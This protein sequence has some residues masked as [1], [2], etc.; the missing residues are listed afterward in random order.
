MA[1]TVA[2]IVLAYSQARRRIESFKNLLE[3]HCR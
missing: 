3:I 1:L 2:T